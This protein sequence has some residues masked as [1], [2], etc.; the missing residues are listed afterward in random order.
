MFRLG[1]SKFTF[2]II[3]LFICSTNPAFAQH[4]GGGHG[5]GGSHGG[6]GGFHGGGG[7]MR[8][9]GSGMSAAPRSSGG[10]AGGARSAPPSGAGSYRSSAGP[11]GNSYRTYAS[12]GNGNRSVAGASPAPRATADGRWHSFGGG[13]GNVAPGTESRASAG[14]SGG[15]W[16]TFGGSRSTGAGQSARSF[17]GQGNQVWEN[18]PQARNV[19]PASRAL[20]NIQGSVHNSVAGNSRL[21]SNALLSAN[22]GLARS[23][24]GS[25][26]AFRTGLG[27]STAVVPFRSTGRFG[28]PFRG[29]RGGCWNCRFGFG[30]GPGWGFGWPWLGFWNWGLA[31]NDPWWGWPGYGYYGYP[32]GYGLYGYDNTYDNGPSSYDSAPPENYPDNDQGTPS[33]QNSPDTSGAQKLNVPV[34]LYMK[35]G[36]VYSVSRYWVASDKLHFV[37]LGGVENSVDMDQFDLQRT[38][39]VNAK[40]GVTFS[41]DPDP[42]A[43]QPAPTT[44]PSP[45][46][47]INLA[48]PPQMHS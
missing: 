7:G 32:A 48:S 43:S 36:S 28:P 42:N 6:G 21:G 3:I 9:G 10:Y 13:T 5:G 15:G 30:W 17:S 23:G 16:Q 37:L 44:T 45:A 40:S 34:L 35:D 46:P 14:N 12:P 39:D 41:L 19:V 20:S 24:L 18:A 22:S 1:F 33:V 31:W 26:T 2:S 38:I 25:G 47:R 4:G 29:F 11:S 27:R 8:G